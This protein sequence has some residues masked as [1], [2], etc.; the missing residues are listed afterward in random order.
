MIRLDPDEQDSESEQQ[1][2][3]PNQSRNATIVNSIE[4]HSSTVTND[5]NNSTNNYS[6]VQNSNTNQVNNIVNAALPM[7]EVFVPVNFVSI[8]LF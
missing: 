2:P 7:Q 1:K 6:H 5:L 8:C 3:A 4:A